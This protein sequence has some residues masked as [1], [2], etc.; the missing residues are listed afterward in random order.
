MVGFSCHRHLHGT[1]AF[2]YVAVPGVFLLPFSAHASQTEFREI[3]DITVVLLRFVA[4]YS[5]FDTMNI[6]FASA[7]KGAGD[8]RFVMRMIFFLSTFVLAL[9]S[10][11]AVTF[12]H[13]DVYALWV[14]A[15]VYV[16]ALGTG[17]LI[18]FLGGK[19]K[20]MRVIEFSPPV[21]ASVPPETP[22][23]EIGI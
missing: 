14:I 7:I 11:I 10:W 13:A 3:R 20:T 1:I 6:I 17:F 2:L 4:V 23:S 8:T 18:R 16:C 12:F 5:L 9:P 22:G 19:W 21:I 15:T